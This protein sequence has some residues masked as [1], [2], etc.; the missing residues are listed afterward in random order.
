MPARWSSSGASWL[1]IVC[2]SGKTSISTTRKFEEPELTYALGRPM[3]RVPAGHRRLKKLI[4]QRPVRATSNKSKSWLHKSVSGKGSQATSGARV[5]LLTA[6]QRDGSATLDADDTMGVFEAELRNEVHKV[7]TFFVSSCACH[8]LR[9]TCNTRGVQGAK[10]AEYRARLQHMQASQKPR[11]KG[12]ASAVLVSVD[13]DTGD[14]TTA[15]TG[16]LRHRKR[17]ASLGEDT[18]QHDAPA[19][20]LSVRS[21]LGPASLRTTRLGLQL[22]AGEDD[23]DND[24]ALDKHEQSL[25]RALIDLYR[26]ARMLENFSMLC[27]TGVCVCVCVCSYVC[28]RV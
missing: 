7:N 9:G 12:D 23:D 15:T 4:F 2:K 14:D 6:S 27:W 24:A 13:Q 10:L 19:S 8:A 22:L 20:P 26:H 28:L 21:G 11:A 25:K 16:S 1:P 3:T 18:K 5:P 17:L